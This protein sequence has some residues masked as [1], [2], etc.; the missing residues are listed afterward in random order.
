MMTVTAPAK[1][2]LTLEALKKRPDGFHEIR[3]VVQTISF[4]DKIKIGA[5]PQ[6]GYQM[7]SPG[8]VGF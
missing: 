8:M 2:N 5:G 1:M 3:S 4:G 6:I 7:Q